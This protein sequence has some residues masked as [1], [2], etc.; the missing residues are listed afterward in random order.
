MGLDKQ[1]FQVGQITIGKLKFYFLAIQ[2]LQ[3]LLEEERSSGF[4]I[5]LLCAQRSTP[6]YTGGDKVDRIF[7][8]W[9]SIRKQAQ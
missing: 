2:Y 6:S 9:S 4:I 8:T 3:R 5:D 1:E 7:K